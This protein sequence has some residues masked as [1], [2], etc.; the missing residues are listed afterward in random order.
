MRE[1]KIL[2]AQTLVKVYDLKVCFMQVF[3]T[4]CFF[5]WLSTNSAI[6][7]MSWDSRTPSEVIDEGILYASKGGGE[8]A[9]EDARI[10]DRH[11]MIFTKWINW[12]HPWGRV[13]Y[14]SN[15]VV[16]SLGL[17]GQVICILWT[18]CFVFWGHPRLCMVSWWRV[19]WCRL[20]PECPVIDFN[21]V[22]PDEYREWIPS[23]KN[24]FGLWPTESEQ[25]GP[26]T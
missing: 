16:L 17:N 25:A 11:S 4:I 5:V 1:I 13:K 6:H 24:A 3:L 2:H 7:I 14:A 23:V 19:D 12:L 8:M 9:L 20:C 21:F 26:H 18:Q 15:I 10:F 22:A